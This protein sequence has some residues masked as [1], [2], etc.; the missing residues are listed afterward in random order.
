MVIELEA[1]IALDPAGNIGEKNLPPLPDPLPQGEREKK[2]NQNAP[3]TKKIKSR[4]LNNEVCQQ[5]VR[6]F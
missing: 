2:E 5:T 1:I 3:T 4:W 6:F